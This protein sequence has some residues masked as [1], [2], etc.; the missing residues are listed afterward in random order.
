M[1]TV[2]KLGM[3]VIVLVVAAGCATTPAVDRLA[4][5]DVA[6][7]AWSLKGADDDMVVA[8]SPARRTLQIAGSAGTLIGAGIAAVSNAKHRRA[9]EKVLEGYDGG[10]AFERILNERLAEVY[11]DG[12]TRVA[13]PR[14]YTANKD[15]REEE[16]ERRRTLRNQG[17]DAALDLDITYG[18]FGYEGTL[19]AKVDGELVSLTDGDKLWGNRIVVSSAP[20]L[21][22]DRLVD[23]TKRALPDF[24]SPRLNV[25]ED[26][27]EQWTR[28]GGTIFRE[29]FEDAARGAAAAM[30]TDMGLAEDPEG[31]HYLGKQL[32]M[33]KKFAEAEKQLRKAV[34]WRP[35][36]VEARNTLAVNQGH[37][38]QVDEAIALATALAADSPDYAPAQYNL[39]WWYAM[40]KKDAGKART[41]YARALELGMAP[42]EDLAEKLGLE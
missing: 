21:A 12:L 3:W 18:L 17:H 22:S 29:R 13:P 30:L 20:V 7:P 10:A 6:H 40:E 42:D 41:H 23:P 38:G 33:Q 4:L 16:L 14:R 5:K 9:V 26:A 36:Y 24:S 27:I 25:N 34:A 2:V 11:G 37:A 15:R 8:V 35:D 1:R 39:A 32:M 31:A 28:D 19:V